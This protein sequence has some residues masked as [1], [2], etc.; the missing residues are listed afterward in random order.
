MRPFKEEKN[1]GL[2]KKRRPEKEWI[3]KREERS[4]RR[5]FFFSRNV[6]GALMSQG[7]Y[8]IE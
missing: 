6:L 1:M 8:K 3:I 4:G 7:F 2:Q 5:N